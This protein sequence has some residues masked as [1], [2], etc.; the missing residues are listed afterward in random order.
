M[1]SQKRLKMI[2]REQKGER[3]ESFKHIEFNKFLSILF[4]RSQNCKMGNILKYTFHLEIYPIAHCF[5][6]VFMSACALQ[7]PTNHGPL[8]ISLWSPA[9]K[10]PSHDSSMIAT[11]T[12]VREADT[13]AVPYSSVLQMGK[14]RSLIC[15]RSC[16]M[17]T[18]DA[19]LKPRVP[20][21]KS[22]ASVHHPSRSCCDTRKA[23]VEKGREGERETLKSQLM[24][25]EFP[26]VLALPS[27]KIF[28]AIAL[29]GRAG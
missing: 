11:I 20:N 17:Q 23:G 24:A 7:N 15:S 1:A 29:K 27:Q 25:Y 22:S 10:T 4:N 6:F 12:P 28:A 8:F 3:R 13:T 19:D 14:W 16:K 26:H 2:Q 9:D 21:S 5:V 18:E